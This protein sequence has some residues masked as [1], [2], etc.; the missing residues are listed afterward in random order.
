MVTTLAQMQSTTSDGT[1]NLAG[2]IIAATFPAYL[3]LLGLV[4]QIYFQRRGA[5]L[6]R[7]GEAYERYLKM[8]WEANAKVGTK[9]H[10]AAKGEYQAALTNLYISASDEVIRAA[11][12]FHRY[13]VEHLN[14]ESK[15][16]GE[17]AELYSLLLSAMRTDLIPNSE[18]TKSEFGDRIGPLL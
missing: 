5:A 10:H 14:N 4:F 6:R 3:G 16:N 7:R 12:D 18:V 1:N 8:F 2:V 13:M 9:E 15:E 17:V 11:T